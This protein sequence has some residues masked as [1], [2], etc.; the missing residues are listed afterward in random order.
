MDAASR[1]SRSAWTDKAAAVLADPGWPARRRSRGP[2]TVPRPGR[3][4]PG[5]RVLGPGL[6]PPGPGIGPARDVGGLTLQL[7]VALQPP[8]LER[9]RLDRGGHRAAG[10]G[11][12]P[13]V[14][15]PAA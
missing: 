3:A 7:A 4:L 5:Y 14:G 2:G 1:P 11:S 8:G 12:V 6:G 10:L 15:E 13:A 9:A